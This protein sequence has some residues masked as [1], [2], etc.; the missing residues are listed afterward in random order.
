MRCELTYVFGLGDVES[1]VCFPTFC[2]AEQ[3]SREKLLNP[4]SFLKAGIINISFIL[5]MNPVGFTRLS[6]L[7]LYSPK[8]RLTVNY[9]PAPKQHR[10]TVSHEPAA[11]EPG[12]F[13]WRVRAVLDICQVDS[14]MTNE[15]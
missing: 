9:L 3:Q 7:S 1:G 2:S 15:C 6:S 10:A 5:G 14:N 4:F 8:P 13:H 12:T 11:E